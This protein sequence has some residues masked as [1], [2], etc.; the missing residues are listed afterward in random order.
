MKIRYKTVYRRNIFQ[1]AATKSTSL[2]RQSLEKVNVELRPANGTSQTKCSF[3]IPL[4][5]SE[6]E[7]PN[8]F[9]L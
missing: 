6:T 5:L 2:T 9:C 7:N 3:K 8:F 4:T 1:Q